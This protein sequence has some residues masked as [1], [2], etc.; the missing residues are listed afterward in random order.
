M[1]ATFVSLKVEAALMAM[2]NG[3]ILDY[4]AALDDILDSLAYKE[5]KL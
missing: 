4:M 2:R 5:V 3:Y 1:K